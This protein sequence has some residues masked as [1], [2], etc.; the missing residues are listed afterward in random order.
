MRDA[1]VDANEGRESTYESVLARM[2]NEIT[3][4]GIPRRDPETR[5]ALSQPRDTPRGI[6]FARMSE[7]LQAARKLVNTSRN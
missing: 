6:K 7:R 4:R 2:I 1:I 5:R 3:T